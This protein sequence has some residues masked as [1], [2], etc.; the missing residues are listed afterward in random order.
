MRG[1]MRLSGLS[2]TVCVLGVVALT[3]VLAACGGSSTPAS[4]SP[5]AAPSVTPS[6]SATPLPTPTVAGT[7][8]FARMLNSANGFNSD[9]YVVNTDGTGLKRLTHDAVWQER[10]SWSPDGSKILFSVWTRQ[11]PRSATI[12][13]MNADGTGKTKLTSGALRGV[14]PNWSPDGRQIAFWKEGPDYGEED[15]YVMSADG[16]AV[17]PVAGG[18]SVWE[19]N[20]GGSENG[21]GLGWTPDGKILFMKTTQQYADVF[22]VNR[23]GSGRTQLTKDAQL[24]TFSLSPDGTRIALDDHASRLY[25]APVQGGGKTVTLMDS[26]YDFMDDLWAGPTWS[27]DGKAL[28]VATNSINLPIG[29]PLYVINADGSGLS[30]VPGVTRAFDAAWRPE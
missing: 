9:I 29:S 14:L 22:A 30:R 6:E 27:P 5:S 17:E 21:G 1:H 26:T 3:A 8:V 2:A 11:S 4:N 10:P 23:D 7:I 25:V 24:G 19:E 15:V 12:W 28:A 20:Q 18:I 16:S 13:V